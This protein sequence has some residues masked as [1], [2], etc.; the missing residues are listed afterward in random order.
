MREECRKDLAG[1]PSPRPFSI[2]V[3]SLHS[4]TSNG[5]ALSVLGWRCAFSVPNKSV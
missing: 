1:I 5:K 3:L 2:E 4:Q